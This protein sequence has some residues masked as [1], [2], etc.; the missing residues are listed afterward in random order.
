MD[1]TQKLKDFQ[2]NKRIFQQMFSM[3]FTQ[4]L[5]DFQTEMFSI[6]FTKK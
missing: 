5:K 6:D 3:D 1:F 2:K 4:K